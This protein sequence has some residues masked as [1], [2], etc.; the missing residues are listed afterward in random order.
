MMG[1]TSIDRQRGALCGG[2]VISSWRQAEEHSHNQ[3]YLGRRRS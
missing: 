1:Y 3:S 2:A